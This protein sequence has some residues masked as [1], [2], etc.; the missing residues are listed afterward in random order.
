MP[1]GIYLDARELGSK[2]LAE[3]MHEII[4]D[5]EKYYNFFRWHNHYSFHQPEED[6]E[7]DIYCKFC[8]KMNDMDFMTRSTVLNHVRE[9]WNPKNVRTKVCPKRRIG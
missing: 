3:R 1:D 5:R 6:P 4:N 8:E 7:T 9:W 2:K